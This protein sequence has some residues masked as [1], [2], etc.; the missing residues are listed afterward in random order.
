M[1]KKIKAIERKEKSLVKD[2]KEGYSKRY[3]L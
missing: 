2:S 1:D 3:P